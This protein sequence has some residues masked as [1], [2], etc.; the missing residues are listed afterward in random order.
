[1]NLY[2]ERSIDAY[3]RS[4]VYSIDAVRPFGVTQLVGWGDAPGE[5]LIYRNDEVVGGGRTSDQQRIVQVDYETS[6]IMFSTGDTFTLQVEHGSMGLRL[7][8]ANII[9][10]YF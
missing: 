8:R 5:F 6:P 2:G 7:M 4:T 10:K 9:G 3:T 1:M